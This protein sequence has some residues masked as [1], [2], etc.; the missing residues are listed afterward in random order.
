[1]ETDRK[2]IIEKTWVNVCRFLLGVTFIFSGFVKA[3]DPLGSFYKIQDY[4]DAFGLLSWVPP[5]MPL[6]FGIGLAAIEFCIGVFLFLGIRRSMASWVALLLMCFMTPLTLYLAIADPVSDCGCFGDAVVLTNWQTFGKNVVLLVAAV[7]AFK[8]RKLIIRFISHKSAWMVSMYTLLFIFA[9]SFYCLSHLP[10]FDFRPYKIGTDINE[11]MSIP[12]GAE[13]PVYATTFILEK[14]GVRREFTLDDYPS[15]TLWKFVDSK[16]EL[17]KEGYEPLIRD[18]FIED[19]KTGD[20][21]TQDILSDTSYVFLLIAY[22][23]HN[24]DDGNIDLINGVYDYCVE[25]GYRF[26]CLTASSDDEILRWQDNTGA[27]Y[28]FCRADDIAL[29]T[30]IRSNPGLMLLKRGVIYN[31][32]SHNTIPSESELC[33][34]LEDIPVGQMADNGRWQTWVDLCV[35]YVLPLCL[36]VV[37]EVAMFSYRRKRNNH[38]QQTIKKD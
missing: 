6:L 23:L 14:D 31:K 35:W 10:I 11:A 18:F 21:L 27:E 13:Q 33:G 36:V 22:D 16:T 32:W 1:M 15:D 17:V 28:D 25:N 26:Y 8:G 38:K 5:F 9:L 4:L 12:E 2:H 34:R 3:V 37:I 7:F 20:D 29:K 30:I 19:I 24:A